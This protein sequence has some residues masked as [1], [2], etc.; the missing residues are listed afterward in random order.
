MSHINC[1][2]TKTMQAH[3]AHCTNLEH[4]SYQTDGIAIWA[5]VTKPGANAANSCHF[6]DRSKALYLKSWRYA[7]HPSLRA[8]EW[9]GNL[10]PMIDERQSFIY[11]MAN[12]TGSVL[13]IGV[14][15][16]LKRRVGE[17]R[18]KTTDGFTKKYNV[19]HLVYYEIFENILQA[20]QREKQLKAGPR[21]RKVEL[22]DRLNPQWNDLYSIV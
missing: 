19:T 18:M 16:N 4:A 3:A 6:F 9:R 21:R 1:H 5:W 20:I 14:T 11:I 13:Y 22:I 17:H 8:T 7:P 10:W 15:N 2:K 12:W